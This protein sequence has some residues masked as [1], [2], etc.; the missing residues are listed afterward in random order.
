[1]VRSRSPGD[2]HTITLSTGYGVRQRQGASMR[3]G[4]LGSGLMGG[5]LGAIFARAGHE[6]VFSYARTR[7]KLET[8]ATAAGHGARAGTVAEAG[9]DAEA[10]LLAIHWSRLD[11]VL[12]QAGDLA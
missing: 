5:K 4:I 10:L 3:I 9:R 1:M 6:V 11:D 12:G 8:L 2:R 7:D